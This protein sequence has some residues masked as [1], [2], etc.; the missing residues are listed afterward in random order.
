MASLQPPLQ[1]YYGAL[2][3][4]PDDRDWKILYSNEQIPDDPTVDLRPYVPQV[5]NQL[6]L[7]SCT[8]NAVVAAFSIDTKKQKLP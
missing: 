7:G 4:P 1:R 8:A 5:L 3:D 6:Q 2:P